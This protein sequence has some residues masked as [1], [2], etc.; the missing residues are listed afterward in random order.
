MTK[1]I[2][3][4]QLFD[5]RD[6]WINLDNVLRIVKGNAP[7]VF[8]VTFADWDKVD[9]IEIMDSMLQRKVANIENGDIFRA[10]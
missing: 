10:L 9:Y 4:K 7:N 8:R 6:L 5:D 3:V 2:K 1:F